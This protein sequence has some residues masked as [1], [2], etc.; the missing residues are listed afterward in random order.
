M[1]TIR[2]NA[3]VLRHT[4]FVQSV[5]KRDTGILNAKNQ[6]NNASI[7]RREGTFPLVAI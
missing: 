5:Q 7:A 3:P 6:G 4:R 2:V 1:V